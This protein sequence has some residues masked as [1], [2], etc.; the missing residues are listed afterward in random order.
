MKA[1]QIAKPYSASIVEINKP[2]FKGNNAV[3]RVHAAG[4]CGSDIGALRGANNLVSYPR[5]IGHELAGE[6][7]YL[8][9]D[10]KLNPKNFKVGDRVVVDPYLYCG[11]CYPCSIGRT[12][13]CEDLKVLGVHVD[14]G[15]C[16]YFA[17]PAHMLVAIPEKIT[18]WTFASMAEPLCIGLHGVHRG[19]V[20]E[21]ETLVIFGA[22][23]IGLMA[24]LVA[25]TYGATPILIDVVDARLQKAKELG[26]DYTINSMKE[27]LVETVKKYNNGNLAHCVIEASGANACIKSS[28]ELVRNAG[29]IVFTGWPK[30]E[31]SIA[32]DIITKK[33][34]DVRGGRTAAREFEEALE[35]IAEEKLPMADILTKT[36]TLDEAPASLLDIE[37]NPSDYLKVVVE[38]S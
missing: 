30:N 27:D 38:L 22:G 8:P 11:E 28:F 32:T 36:I 5:V 7:V 3:I 15:M 33:E 1:V 24:A 34:L 12:N 2:E 9:E 19:A 35:L 6:I 21:G 17:H 29:R 23:T 10:E 13:C 31:T 37:K 14:G 26:I 16:E 20:K 25:K 18:S 4:I